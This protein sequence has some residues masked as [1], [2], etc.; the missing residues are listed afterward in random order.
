MDEEEVNNRFSIIKIL[1]VFILV[2]LS[3]ALIEIIVTHID[4]EAIDPKKDTFSGKRADE[5]WKVISG[6]FRDEA[7]E[8]YNMTHDYILQKLYS[9]KNKSDSIGVLNVTIEKQYGVA[10]ETAITR[11]MH[12]QKD[13]RNILVDVRAKGDTRDPIAIIAHIDG[14]PLGYAAYDDGAGVACMLELINAI[15]ESDTKIKNPVLFFFDGTEEQGL[16]GALLFAKHK[17][18]I[19]SFLNIESMGQ[20]LP[21]SL[22]QKGDNPYPIIKAYTKAKRTVFATFA[23]DVTQLGLISSSSDAVVFRDLKIAGAEVLYVGNPTRYHTINDTMIT[24][25]HLQLLGDQLYAVINNYDYTAEKTQAGAIG[26][27]PLVIFMKRSVANIIEFCCLGVAVAL[28]IFLIVKKQLNLKE[29]YKSILLNLFSYILTFGV[30]ML[31]PLA[32][33]YINS[34]SYAFNPLF[35]LI[36]L[37]SFGLFIFCF[38]TSL[39]NVKSYSFDYQYILI[40]LDAI[41]MVVCKGFD[42]AYVLIFRFVLSLIGLIFIKKYQ[43]VTLICNV[44]GTVPITFFIYMTFRVLVRY[45]SMIAGFIGECVPVMII[46]LYLLVLLISLIPVMTSNTKENDYIKFIYLGLFVVLAITFM[47]LPLVYG[48]SY[49]VQGTVAQL[50]DDNHSSVLSFAPE[51][52][53]RVLRMLDNEKHRIPGVTYDY[54]YSRPFI[55]LPAFTEKCNGSIPNFIK[56][57]PELNITVIKNT[58]SQNYQREVHVRVPESNDNI[59]RLHFIIMCDFVKCLEKVEGFEEPVNFNRDEKKD[60]FKYYFKVSPGFLP[61]EVNFTVSGLEKIPLTFAFTS[62]NF[63]KELNTFYNKMP[64]Y[65]KMIG[66]T[67]TMSE[68]TLLNYTTI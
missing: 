16:H 46:C 36:S 41:F 4:P 34:L 35:A 44:I 13:V 50:F 1:I 45:T 14:N 15:T 49:Y 38:F 30:M 68:T 47:C 62:Y 7:T 55:S 28:T 61:A 9:Y 3:A 18:N 2:F 39:F 26:I 8:E 48:D 53:E 20:G 11:T 52:G 57:W 12:S 66:K 24:P 56:K 5:H 59:H 64:Y 67:R 42:F 17:K 54:N 25:N 21:L 37:T 60:G 19:S 63:S 58:S 51:S 22:M 27:Y 10:N 6:V 43:I 29:N 32:L 65:F 33:Y 40:I 31:L 23:D